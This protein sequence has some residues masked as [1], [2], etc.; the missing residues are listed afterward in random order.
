MKRLQPKLSEFRRAYSSPEFSQK[1]LQKWTPPARI[2]IDLSAI[3]NAIVSE[4]ED[5]VELGGERPLWRR[6]QGK[7]RGKEFRWDG[8]GDEEW[9]PI[10]LL[11]TRLR[12]FER[13]SSSSDFLG[14][15]KSIE[16]V[17]KLKASL[18]CKI[19]NLF[20]ISCCRI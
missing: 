19:L 12:E 9:E 20:N 16:F 6:G 7:M 17:E 10:R 13:K 8:K 3:R 15:F 4:V 1:V 2:R 11:K 5:S 18:V 14:N